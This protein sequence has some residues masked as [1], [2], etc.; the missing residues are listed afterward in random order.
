MQGVE[1]SSTRMEIFMKEAGNI[2]YTMI[3]FLL[4]TYYYLA[5]EYG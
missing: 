1:L 5:K 2:V 3:N 4:N